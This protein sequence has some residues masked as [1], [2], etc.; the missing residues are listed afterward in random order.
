MASLLAEQVKIELGPHLFRIAQASSHSA[1]G[2]SDDE[3]MTEAGESDDGEHP[4]SD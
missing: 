1:A 4:A 3:E 2:T